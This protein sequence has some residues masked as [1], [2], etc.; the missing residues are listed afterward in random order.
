MKKTSKG[1]SR[2][3]SSRKK[4]NNLMLYNFKSKTYKSKTYKSPSPSPSPS[5]N[6]GPTYNLASPNL[7]PTY[8]P[9]SSNLGP[10][11]NLASPNLTNNSAN[12]EH[13]YSIPFSANNE[14]P[15]HI[16][17]NYIGYDKANATTYENP[18]AVNANNP[19]YNTAN[20][21]SP[22]KNSYM[23]LY[24]N[25]NGYL[26]ILPSTESK[27][28]KNMENLIYFLDSLFNK[29]IKTTDK[30]KTCCREIY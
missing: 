30:K 20:S 6:L 4:G 25:D 7:G 27:N 14:N 12:V 10:T 16:P 11:Y 22:N 13:I 24:T 26:T 23:E 9:A 5:Q 29:L 8:Y 1:R 3:N 21:Q 17:P 19:T 15:Y 18:Y 2:K 28:K